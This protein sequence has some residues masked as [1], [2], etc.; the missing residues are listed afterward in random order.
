MNQFLDYAIT[1]ADAIVTYCASDMILVGHSEAS[2]L[3]KSKALSHAGGHFFL[4]WDAEDP[5]NIGPVL[6]MAKIIKHVMLSAA[7]A[8][9]GVLYIN[10]REAIPTSML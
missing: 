8:K 4:L 5:P 1:H 2:Y 10:C 7:E 6:T 9:A 3:S